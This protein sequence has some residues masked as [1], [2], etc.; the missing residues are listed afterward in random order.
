MDGG[1]EDATGAG[2]G[3]GD[4][5]GVVG[6]AF[7]EADE[8]EEEDEVVRVAEMTEVD[9]DPEDESDPPE[10]ESPPVNFVMTSPASLETTGHSTRFFSF[11][12]GTPMRVFLSTSTGTLSV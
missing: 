7:G 11:V 3:A 4:F 9:E 6:W 2:D 1:A 12:I 8:E 5:F 10:E